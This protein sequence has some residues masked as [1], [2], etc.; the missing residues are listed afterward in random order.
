MIEIHSIADIELLR[1]SVDLECKRA[2]GQDGQ[3]ALPHDFWES[4]SAMA[5]TEGGIIL[6]GVQ[7]KKGRFSVVSLLN[8]DRIRKDLVDTANNPKKASVNL[9]GNHSIRELTIEGKVILQ[10]EIPRASRTQRPVFLNGNPLH[11]NAYRRFHEADQKLSD[12][13]VK[14]MLAEQA[15][16]SLDDR[17]L[18]H[19]DIEDL[20]ADSLRIY[21]QTHATLNPGHVWSGLADREFL[22]AI[23]AWRKN[24][25]TGEAGLTVAGLLMF[26]THP[27][28]QEQ[29]PYYMLD[30]QERPEAKTERRWID[31]VT[32]DGTWSGNLYDF[33]RKVYPKLVADLKVPFEVRDGVR[34][35]DTPVHVALREALANVIVHSDYRERAS[36]FVVKRPDM[37][38]FRNP[39]L[40]RIPPA[41]ALR[42]DE[43]DC[44]NRLL[45]AMFRY[46]NVGEQAGSGIPKILSGWSSQHWRM[47]SLREEREPN[48]RTV[49]ELQMLDLFPTGIL[50][51]L[52]L[53]FKERFE[54]LPQ[55]SR[56]A[57]AITLSEGRLTH[58][59]LAELC[60][61]H[62]SDVSKT[63]RELV[64]EGF[65]TISGGG[66]GAVYRFEGTPVVSP[67]DVFGGQNL[68]RGLRNLA[69]G[70]SNLESSSPNLAPRSPNL[71]PSSPNL[72]PER[73]E[74]G[75]L[76]SPHHRLP[77]VDDFSKLS[78]SFL[79]EL[80]LIAAEPVNKGK[81]PGDVMKNVILAL[82]RDQYVTVR[83]LASLVN[84]QPE[85]LRGQY[86]STMWRNR[87]LK[88][89]FPDS[90]NDSRQA[91]TSTP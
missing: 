82:C 27:V 85:T 43:H 11:G 17:I 42:G 80:A 54:S 57:L 59:R 31:R 38:G 79:E 58:G 78:E 50:D 3:G 44:R 71:A 64:K 41:I 40:M 37:F 56:L 68:G 19:F 74:N 9:L 84:R 55:I 29:F 76:L 7:E 45:H 90:P 18:V 83:C 1:E 23:G 72:A 32:L 70:S 5:N 10:V 75:R 66:R 2:A 8:P 60:H 73:D 21:R 26:G 89:A 69:P 13:E 77:F 34:Q 4:Y 25:E 88:L 36:V 33:Y 22:K 48:N 53:H 52:K 91:Y 15:H 47:P 51:I 16:D 30:Y 87:E 62:A 35:E 49:L 14:R 12:D 63:L 39:G 65:L 86:L 28:I 6:L 61:E 67:D 20:D 24:R 81:I 46:V